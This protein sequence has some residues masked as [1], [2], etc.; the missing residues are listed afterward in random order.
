MPPGRP[1]TA[2][3]PPTWS[4]WRLPAPHAA[5]VLN[6]LSALPDQAAAW[7]CDVWFVPIRQLGPVGS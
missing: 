4:A 3:D 7:L 6:S 5:V 1:A 2:E